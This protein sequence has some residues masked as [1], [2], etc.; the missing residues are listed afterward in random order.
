MRK[1]DATGAA[2]AFFAACCGAMM[3]AV[4][5]VRARESGLQTSSAPLSFNRDIRPILSNNCFACHGPDEGKRKTKF[6][7]DTKEGAFAKEG[8]VI[9]GNATKSLLIWRVTHEDPEERMPPPESGHTLTDKQIALLRR[10]IDEGATWDSHWAYTAPVRPEPPPVRKADWARNPIDRFILARLEREGLAPSP[11]ANKETL[12]R[13]LSY[14]LTGLP[15]TPEEVDSFLADRSPDA[16]ERRVDAL[17]NSPRYGERMAMPWLD[18]ARYADTHGYHIDSHRGMWP[19]R[20]WVIGAFNRNL[21]FDRFVIEQLA[22]DLLTNP[23]REQKIASGFNRNHMI[24]FE[25]GA[26]ADEYQVEY[27]IDRV[28]ATSSAFLGLTMGCARCHS[29]KFD[30]ITHKEFYQFFA[31]F[32]NVPELG[33]DGRRGNAAPFLLLPSHEQETLLEELDV[34]IEARQIALK[35]SAVL[36][37]QVAW[38]KSLDDGASPQPIPGLTAHYELDGNFSDISGRYQHG[39]TI[40]GDPTFE[41]GQLGRGAVFDGD[42]EVSFGKVGGFDRTNGFTL[43]VW[44]RPS[45]KQPVNVFQKIDDTARR[46]GFEW[47]LEDIVLVDIQR[48]AARLTVT[49]ASDSPAGAIQVRTRDRLRFGE[50]YHVTM[51]YDGSGKAAGLHLY[52]DGKRAAVDVVRDALSGPVANDAALRVGS[53]ALGKPFVGQ[54]DDLRLYDRALTPSEIEQIAIHNPPRAILSGVTGKRSKDEAQRVREYFLTYAAPTP[55]REAYAELEALA[56]ERASFVKGIPNAMVMSEREKPR[57]TFVLARGDYRNQTD[58]VQ[59]GVPAMLPPLPK[60][61][62]LNRLTL[63]NWLVQANH[64]LTARVAVNR[65]WQMYFG[66]GIVKTQE[67]FGVQGEPPVHPELLDWLATEFIRTGWDVRAMQRLIVTSATYRQSSVVTPALH[68]KDP[69]NRLLARGPRLRLPAEMI[70]DTALAASGLLNGEIGG[71]SVFPYQPAGLWEEMAFGEGYS[72]QAYQQSHGKDLYRRGLYTFW[73]RTVPPASL[74]TFDAPDREKCAARR[75]L[76]NT[77]LQAL[78]LLNDPSYVEAARGLAERTLREGGVD[79]KS[80]VAYAFRL[81]TARTPSGKE[82]AVL[83]KL[84]KERLT[85]FRADSKA[86]IKLLQVGES[87]RDKR[88][89]VVEHAAWTTV[90]S[91][92]LNLDETITKQ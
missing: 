5:V 65:F 18:A 56:L 81:A 35:D 9:P 92:I 37:L 3:F 17:L 69:D 85:S 8:I 6:H 4:T 32:N 80:R 21:P 68:E 25:G 55:L 53:R 64:P 62:P 88:L 33:L 72:A 11:E 28:E 76:T 78:V 54:I 73:K 46:R 29:H 44:L 43:G 57:D 14:D 22:G 41:P 70:R 36:P 74:A 71:P 87:P 13:R 86:A 45:G 34:A 39:R 52:L 12:L 63:A 7:F 51:T 38:E 66:Y 59:P 16:Y 30:P 89:D 19:W 79:E 75:A 58:K 50:S 15:P 61:A 82:V 67:D 90:A 48:W 10:W 20:D 40:V 47:L 1:L 2:V 24:N 91:V 83:R 26:I 23:T 84:L 42:T 27:V 60:D 77:P 31:F 49:L